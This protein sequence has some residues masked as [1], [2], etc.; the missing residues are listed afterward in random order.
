MRRVSVFLFAFF[1]LLAVSLPVAGQGLKIS[2]SS[3]E[4]GT[5]VL[6]ELSIQDG[7]L[8]FRVD[9]GGCTDAGSFKVRASRMDG[10]PPNKAHYQLTIERVRIDECKAMLWEGVQIELDLRKDLGLNGKYTVTVGNPVLADLL[11]ATGRAIGLETEAT[12]QKLKAAEEGTGPKDNVER[13][14]QRLLDLKAEQAKFG[15]LAPEGYPAPIEKPFDPASVLEESGGFGPIL[16]PEI[17]EVAATVEGPLA[18]GALLSV[19]GTSKSGPFYH[20]AGIAGGDYRLLKPGKEY[21]LQLCLV[22]RREYFGLIG[23]YFVYILGAR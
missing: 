18:D 8:R 11:A 14:R 15:S 17:R 1:A 21:R 5:S 4:L 19:E 7:K 3:R 2:R 12:R 13:L 20:L 23:D 9:S 10:V 6:R 16:P 22:Y